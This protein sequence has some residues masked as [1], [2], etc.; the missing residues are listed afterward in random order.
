MNSLN[1]Q[2]SREQNKHTKK[3]H[4]AKQMAH[5]SNQR[6]SFPVGH[7]PSGQQPAAWVANTLPRAQLGGGAP[8]VGPLRPESIQRLYQRSCSAERSVGRG[9]RI[10]VLHIDS[11]GRLI[12]LKKTGNGS[13]RREWRV[14]K[15]VKVWSSRK[16]REKKRVFRML[17]SFARLTVWSECNLSRAWKTTFWITN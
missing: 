12:C 13:W 14:N 15:Q 4:K 16:K 7:D 5:L 11:Q 9:G 6:L 17:A 10:Q 8:C 2:R 3:L 1:N